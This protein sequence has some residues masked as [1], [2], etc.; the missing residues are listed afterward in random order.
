VVQSEWL[1]VHLLGSSDL[2]QS[3]RVI[4]SSQSGSL[5]AKSSFW[6]WHLLVVLALFL[7]AVKRVLS[8]VRIELHEFK[9][10]WSISLIFGRCVIALPILG[11]HESDNFSDFAFF[12]RHG[13]NLNTVQ[14][15]RQNL[16][17][18]QQLNRFATPGR[19]FFL[20]AP[21]SWLF[22]RQNCSGA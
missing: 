9:S 3:C 5:V 19:L 2:W 21:V 11:T 12:L 4:R 8:Q 22:R 15:T 6:I 16:Y 1:A 20:G 14:R 7:L 13:T 10:I 17:Y 18:V